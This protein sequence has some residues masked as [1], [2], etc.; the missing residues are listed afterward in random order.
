ML[1][2]QELAERFGISE[3]SVR[4]RLDSLS[5]V[6]GQ[7]LSTGRQNAIL[8]TDAGLAIFDRCMQLERQDK[9]SPSS[10]VEK[11]ISEIQT[12]HSTVFNQEKSAVQTQSSDQSELVRVLNRQIE[13]L[14]EERNRLLTIVESQ[15]DQIKALM[16]GPQE[17]S[18]SNERRFT[19]FQALRFVLLG[20]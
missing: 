16:P 20:R 10:S 4:R 19:R 7:H 6:I 2:I 1:T 8:V 9:L 18:S 17:R 12:S 5:S 14:R 13:D 11:V 3:K 15:G